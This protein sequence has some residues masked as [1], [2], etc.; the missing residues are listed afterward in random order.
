MICCC[1]AV[2]ANG[3][4]CG[5]DFGGAMTT[6]DRIVFSTEITSAV[7]GANLT[8]ARYELVG[9]V[10]PDIAAYY[11]GGVTAAGLSVVA[12]KLTFSSETTAAV[13]TANLPN[14]QA[15]YQAGV[16]ERS[17]KAY[18]AGGYSTPAFTVTKKAHKLT[19]SGESTSAVTTA[20]I[21]TVRYQGCGVTDGSTKGYFLGGATTGGGTYQVTAD[22]L[23]YSSD[24]TAAQTSANLSLGRGGSQSCSEGTTYGY[25]LGGRTVSGLSSGT[26]G[27]T[28]RIT[29]STDTTAARTAMGFASFEGCGMSDGTR[30]ILFGFNVPP[31]TQFFV[32]KLVFSTEA[33]TTLG[34][35]AAL[36]TGRASYGGACTVGL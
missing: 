13:T 28:D 2:S 19:F 4:V 33:I 26:V 20:D 7:T 16:S 3:Y 14:A 15:A 22:K 17:T 31:A 29:F 27:T 24:T 23:T 1:N 30:A 8:V 11:L 12:D 25:V 18:V 35:S 6:A 34:A 32:S 21:S 36:S 9:L 5:G 10:N